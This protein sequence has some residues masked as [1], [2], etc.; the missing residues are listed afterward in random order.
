MEEISCTQRATVKQQAYGGCGS[1][2]AKSPV[3]N[4][5]GGSVLQITIWAK[6]TAY[7]W[8]EGLGESSGAKKTKG[9]QI[10]AVPMDAK[11]GSQLYANIFLNP[12]D[13]IDYNISDWRQY[14]LVITVSTPSVLLLTVLG[15][16]PLTVGCGASHQTPA[17]ATT[18]SFYSRLQGANIKASWS[19]SDVTI[20]QVDNTLCNVIRT[21][22]TDVELWNRDHTTQYVQDSDFSVLNPEMA[23]NAIVCDLDVLH[24]YVVKRLS[25]GAIGTGE[26]VLLSYDFLP[27]KVDVEGH[28]TPNAFAEP[29][30][31]PAL[32]LGWHNPLLTSPLAVTVITTAVG[33]YGA[34]LWLTHVHRCA[35]QI[36]TSWTQ[37]LVRWQRRS[38]TSATSTST[39]M[40][41]VAWL[42]TLARSAPV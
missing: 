14:T 4:I 32:H 3:L 21:N 5:T 34:R 6:L 20:V 18:V 26:Q 37:R 9:P 7:S 15:D 41:F 35:A 19:I 33:R 2:K 25:G 28:S 17:N 36:T 31:K 10:T 30:C 11:G 39:M 29:E 1:E 27:G 24:P 16:L 22:A 42:E 8:R 13:A 12:H 23:N 38:T 40:R